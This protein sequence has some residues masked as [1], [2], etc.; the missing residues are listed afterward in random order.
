M[1]TTKGLTKRYGRITAVNAVD[2][3]VPDGSRFGLLGPN[4]SGKT[5]MIRML[6][7]LVYATSGEINVLGRAGAEAA[8]ARSC[9]RSARSSRARPPTDTCPDGPTSRCSTRLAPVHRKESNASATRWIG[10]ASAGST[11]ARCAPIRSAC[12]S[13]S[14]WPPR[15]C[16]RPGC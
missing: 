11:A 5:T 3:D 16:G 13:G 14:A 4:G 1:I 6:L 2:L 12:A 10:S 8:Q 15:C 9:R 7:G